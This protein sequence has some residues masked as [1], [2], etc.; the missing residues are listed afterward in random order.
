MDRDELIAYCLAKPGAEETYP[1]GEGEMV[2]KVGGRG[3]AF[4]GLGKAPSGV[5]LKCGRDADDAAVWRDRYPESITT[6][7]YI[8]RFGW[9]SVQLDGSIP[10]ED[11][12]ELLDQSYDAIV[13]KLPKAKRPAH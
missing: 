4:I 13:A 1:F 3:F 9:N 8:G 6:S 5:G 2:A 12:Q 7:A 11:L 10:S